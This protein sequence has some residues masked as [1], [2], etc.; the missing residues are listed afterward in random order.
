MRCFGSECETLA[1]RREYLETPARGFGFVSISIRIVVREGDR[2]RLL[3]AAI[4]HEARKA[5]Q[6]GG[7]LG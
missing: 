6:N 7:G 3:K 4:A 5:C 1:L 2:S